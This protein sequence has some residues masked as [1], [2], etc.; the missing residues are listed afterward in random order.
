MKK[1]W[2]SRFNGFLKVIVS[3]VTRSGSILQA[4]TD[5]FVLEVS[6]SRSLNLSFPTFNND[7]SNL[8]ARIEMNTLYTSN[9]KPVLHMR[10]SSE[11]KG[12]SVRVL[13]RLIVV[14]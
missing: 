11:L 1:Y 14:V 3:F 8:G 13:L 9:V 4:E 2:I 6:V 10:S 12:A 7:A 5:L